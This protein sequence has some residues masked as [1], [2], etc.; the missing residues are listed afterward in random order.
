MSPR[1]NAKAKHIESIEQLTNE[2]SAAYNR[3]QELGHENAEYREEV[4]LMR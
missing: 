1:V 2:L 4:E 3:I